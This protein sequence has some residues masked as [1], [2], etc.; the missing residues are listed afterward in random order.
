MNI[1][2]TGGTGLIGRHLTALLLAEGHSVAHLTRGGGPGAPGVRTFCWNPAA[3]RLDPAAVAWAHGIVHLAGAG[4]MDAR[5]TPARKQEVVA[6]RVGGLHLLRDALAR[7]GHRVRVLVSASAIGIYGDR[8]DQWLTENTPPPAPGAAGKSDFLAD[9]CRQWEAAA[10]QIRATGLRV[11]IVRIGIVLSAL[12]GALPQMAQPVRLGAGAPLGTGRQWTSWIHALDVARLLAAALTDERYIGTY[13]AVAPNPVTN[14][15]LT[16][17]I[18]RVLGRPL[19]LP[20]VPAFALRLLLGE[21]AT[22]VLASQ[23]VRPDAAAALG[24]E[25]RYAAVERAL[26]EA[27]GGDA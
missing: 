5:W 4:V 22:A 15:D 10:L 20:P 19:L 11:P 25:W 26:A 3:H 8:G 17:A 1:L 21:R 27:L 14:A 23:R 24:F 12:G 7:G 9:V 16:R 18:A 13:N 2:I 6:S